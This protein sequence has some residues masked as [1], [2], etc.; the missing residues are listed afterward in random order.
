MLAHQR[1]CLEVILRLDFEVQKRACDGIGNLLQAVPRDHQTPF[2]LNCWHS[3]QCESWYLCEWALA[4]LM[5][6][7]MAVPLTLGLDVL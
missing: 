5:R 2:R 4:E 6:S 7:L 1:I 3:S